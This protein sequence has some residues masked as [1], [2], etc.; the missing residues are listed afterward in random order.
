MV[1]PAKREFLA[2]PPVA[3]VDH[4]CMEFN[5]S[6]SPGVAGA[7]GVGKVENKF[8]ALISSPTNHC[9]GKWNTPSHKSIPRDDVALRGCLDGSR[10]SR[11]AQLH[12]RSRR[13]ISEV[14]AEELK[15][16]GTEISFECSGGRRSRTLPRG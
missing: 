14:E 8:R 9:T 10:S 4:C 7:A 1:S 15:N 2:S 6:Q 12:G 11:E 5:S 16:R 13:K 3:K